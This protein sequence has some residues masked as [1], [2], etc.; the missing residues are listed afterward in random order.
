[1]TKKKKLEVKVAK[2][3]KTWVVNAIVTEE[4]R[5]TVMLDSVDMPT[6]EALYKRLKNDDYE[7]ILEEQTLDILE[8]HSDNFDVETFED[9]DM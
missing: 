4:R 3:P 5:L 8:V 2:M 9:E 7:S 1:M 6:P